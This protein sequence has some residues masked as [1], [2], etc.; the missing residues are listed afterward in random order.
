M[1][2]SSHVQTDKVRRLVIADKRKDAAWRWQ[3]PAR[4]R[5]GTP[6][7]EKAGL[8]SGVYPAYIGFDGCLVACS[9]KSAK[10]RHRLHGQ[11]GD[12]IHHCNQGVFP[13]IR[14]PV[15]GSICRR[16]VLGTWGALQARVWLSRP[17]RVSRAAIFPAPV[18]SDT[19]LSIC[20][21]ALSP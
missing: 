14:P 8:E 20:Q 21:I 19:V 17:K 15:D 16:V 4:S 1:L 6:V 13:E 11:L 10:L 5:S 12:P 7:G 18:S 3:S 2:S 9:S